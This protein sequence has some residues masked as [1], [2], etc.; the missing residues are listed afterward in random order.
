M[1]NELTSHA[2]VRKLRENLS[3]VGIREIEVSEHIVCWEAVMPG[4]G[5]EAP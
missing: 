1:V 4:E 2:Y 3:T 5:L